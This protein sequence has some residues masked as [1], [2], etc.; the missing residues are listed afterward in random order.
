MSLTVRLPDEINSRL[1]SLAQQTGRSKSFYVRKA[2]EEKLEDLEDLYLGL[3][4]LENVKSG[5]E[6]VLSSE[7]MWSVLDD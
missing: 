5:K 4:M 3:A 6:E 1:T 7:E 2:I